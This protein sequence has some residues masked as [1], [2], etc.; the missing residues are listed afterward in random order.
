[1]LHKLLQRVIAFTLFIAI[2]KSESFSQCHSC[3]DPAP[4]TGQSACNLPAPSL[5]GPS[6]PSYCLSA[7]ACSGTA[8]SYT[9]T[10]PSYVKAYFFFITGGNV[11]SRYIS[12]DVPSPYLQYS[13]SPAVTQPEFFTFTRGNVIGSVTL[14]IRWTT[15]SNQY[16]NIEV[17]GYTGN[18]NS[19]QATISC[20]GCF[21]VTPPPTLPSPPANLHLSSPV[22]YSTPK[23]FLLGNQASTGATSYTWSGYVSYQTTYVTGPFV[24]AGQSVYECV[25]ANNACGAS[26]PTCSTIYIPNVCGGYRQAIDKA[27]KLLMSKKDL[28]L[29]TELN[30]YPNPASN[31]ISV[32]VNGEGMFMAEIRSLS[33]QLVY[34]TNI[35]GQNPKEI[36]VSK[37]QRGIYLISVRNKA[38]FIDHQKIILQ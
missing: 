7:S 14:T 28:N 3:S 31:R 24:A 13:C 17:Y 8:Y 16:N 29:R 21:N 22:C 30:V 25:A 5:Y 20:Y 19:N 34:T 26:Q 18:E 1:M 6:N 4:Y 9:I 23:G 37:L 33:G 27:K 35:I 15:N 32:F 12:G 36:D 11:M 38:I 2:N 10:F